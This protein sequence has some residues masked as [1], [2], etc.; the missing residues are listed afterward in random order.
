MKNT[1][2]NLL[3]INN[4]C[5]GKFNKMNKM[6]VIYPLNSLNLGKIAHQFSDLYAS[7][8]EE[9]CKCLNLE[10]SE[11]FLLN[12]LVFAEKPVT[13]KDLSLCVGKDPALIVRILDKLEAKKYIIRC[14]HPEDRR[15]YI[16]QATEK[17][18]EYK[19]EFEKIFSKTNEKVKKNLTDAEFKQLNKL[20]QKA[21]QGLKETNKQ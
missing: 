15:A 21:V 14:N 16:I 4:Y 7:K 2:D 9:Y 5:R 11:F 20:L 8:I 18:M 3:F 17:S 6:K 10:L 1:L 12:S 19:K 13:Q